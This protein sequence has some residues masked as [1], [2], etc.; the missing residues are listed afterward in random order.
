MVWGV[1]SWGSGNHRWGPYPHKKGHVWGCSG[2]YYQPYLPE[3]R[4]YASLNYKSI[5]ATCCYRTRN[6]GTTINYFTTIL[7]GFNGSRLTIDRV[8]CRWCWRGVMVGSDVSCVPRHLATLGA[9]AWEIQTRHHVIL[10]YVCLSCTR[11]LSLSLVFIYIP[12]VAL[13]YRITDSRFSWSNCGANQSSYR[14]TSVSLKVPLNI[15][16]SLFTTLLL[17]LLSLSICASGWCLSVC[18]V[19]RLPAPITG[20]RSISAGSREQQRPASYTAIR[21]TRIDTVYS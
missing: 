15:R 3:G 16:Y 20:Y 18:L 11:S 21:G 5:A 9:A 8:L 19:D 2:P 6:N 10:R 1:D 17:T 7:V 13:M 4:S 14:Q 12:I